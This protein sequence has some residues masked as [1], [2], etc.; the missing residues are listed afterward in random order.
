MQ[1][2]LNFGLIYIV[3]VTVLGICGG[4][5]VEKHML[6]LKTG[7]RYSQVAATVVLVAAYWVSQNSRAFS[8]LAGWNLVALLGLVWVLSFYLVWFA[9]AHQLN[10]HAH[11]GGSDHGTMLSMLYTDTEFH[12]AQKRARKRAAKSAEPQDEEPPQP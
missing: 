9:V 1:L 7:L 11:M 10:K 4:V 3:L 2:L 12:K 5:L 6:N 8:G